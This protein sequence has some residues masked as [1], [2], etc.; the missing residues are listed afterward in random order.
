MAGTKKGVVD[1]P[2]DATQMGAAR[3]PLTQN[4]R[5]W[6]GAPPLHTAKREISGGRANGQGG[7]SVLSIAL[8]A[9]PCAAT[10]RGRAR[11][12]IRAE[13]CPILAGVRPAEKPAAASFATIAGSS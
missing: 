7:G 4:R 5:G 10:P 9:Y 6:K 3:D 13:L 12:V 11:N 2:P 8:A 1:A